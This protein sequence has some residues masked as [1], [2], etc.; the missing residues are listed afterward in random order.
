MLVKIED[1]L[2]EDILFLVCFCYNKM[3]RNKIVG[4]LETSCLST[5]SMKLQ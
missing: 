3:V 1:V 2:N 5:D 4:I